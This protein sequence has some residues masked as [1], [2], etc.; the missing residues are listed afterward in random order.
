MKNALCLFIFLLI[1]LGRNNA[2]SQGLSVFNI[3]ASSFPNIKAKFFA[4]DAD[5]KQITNLSP[6]DFT[7]TEN[8]QP[9]VVTNVSCPEIKEPIALS[10]VLVI[11][12][13]GSM[14]GLPLAMAKAAANVWI[15]MIPLGKSE[16]A[17]TS[18]NGSSFVNQDFTTNKAKLV[19]SLS[20]LT[21]SDGTNYDAAF[22]GSNS[23]GIDVAKNG[24]HKRIIVFI[25]DG[26]GL[27]TD[28][29]IS[30]ANSY[31]IGVY[32]VTLGYSAPQC[33]KDISQQT[34]GLCFENI[35]TVQEA[36]DCYRKILTFAQ[37][38][39]PC[40]I[41][42]K[43]DIACSA[44]LRSAEVSLT[45]L[46]FTTNT[47]Y[48]SPFNTI[49][50]IEFSPRSIRFSQQNIGIKHDT[51]VTVKAKNSDFNVTGITSSNPAF[52][53]SPTSFYLQKDQSIDLTVSITP[54]DSAYTS[55]KF[56]FDNDK[57]PTAYYASGGTIGKKPKIPTLKLIHPN[58]G[59]LFV[60]GSDTV[61]T[62]DG[63][64]PTDTV[65]LEY[66]I[67][68]GKHWTFITDTANNF[69]YIWK[70]IPPPS[71]NVCLVK[72]T[73]L[74]DTAK[75]YKPGTLINTLESKIDTKYRYPNPYLE[76]KWN[77][78]SKLCAV[79][80]PYNSVSICDALNGKIMYELIGH[81]DMITS[82]SWS[83]F[84]DFIAT[85]SNDK[86]VKIWNSSNGSNLMTLQIPS[87]ALYGVNWSPDGTSVVT[88]CSNGTAIIWDALSGGI[89]NTL[90]GHKS[91]VNSAL[92]SPNGQYIGTSST[93][94]TV[95]IWEAITGNE[96]YTFGDTTILGSIKSVAWSPFGN[97]IS[98]STTICGFAVWDAVTKE[99]INLLYG[100][101]V[102]S[103]DDTRAAVV[104]PMAKTVIYDIR[105]GKEIQI[106]D[107]GAASCWNPDGTKLAT[108]NQNNTA[109]VWNALTGEKICTLTGHKNYLFSINWS[110][111]GTRLATTSLDSTAKIWY[112]DNVPLEVQSDESDAVFSIVSPKAT[113]KDINMGKC[114]LNSSKDSLV[115]EFISNFDSYKFRVDSIY[116][117]GP[118]AD[119]FRL[120]SGYPK[121]EVNP[122]ESKAAEFS[123][124]PKRIG[125]HNATINIITQSETLKQNIQGEG[126][127]QALEVISKLL[128]FGLVDL[129]SEKT[130]QDTVLIKNISA[131]PIDIDNVVQLGPD[132]K[133]F[134]IINGGGQFTLQPNES[135]KLTIRF[136][137]VYIGRTS[138]QLGFEYNGVGSPAIVQLF[139]IGVGGLLLSIPIDSAY[140]G[141]ER[142]LR[143]VMSNIKPEN[144]AAI[145][146]NFEAIIRFQKTIIT[147]INKADRSIVND[148]IYLKIKGTIGTS[149][150][151]AQIPVIAGLGFVEETTID[152]VDF[153]FTDKLGTKIDFDIET[154]SGTF[155]LLGICGEGGTRLINPTGKV[156]ILQIIPN[157]A[158]D[159]IEINV[160]LI[161][162]VATSLSVFNS[163][164]IKLKD[165]NMAGK[166]GLQTIN[167][168]IREFDNGL[169]FIKLQTPTVVE[170]QKL[171]II[172]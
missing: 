27:N 105:T 3:D 60:V 16:C 26:G 127:E 131:T 106:L 104:R 107:G 30:E 68:N 120:V 85:S 156:E 47:N 150:E 140:A 145:A 128:D 81:K 23:G 122:S 169:Y 53:I 146:S 103:P 162:D 8:G 92:W 94:R 153:K 136:K 95:K 2:N 5:G 62:W 126:V 152:I 18:F 86:T 125:I 124:I 109:I 113:S 143:L 123:F 35:M 13:S 1:L 112:V 36:E 142:S 165:F 24:K 66:S 99:L 9:R 111:D 132:K 67:D 117:T 88:P 167:L 84:G 90:T 87:A 14:D 64:L 110:P 158:S 159:D 161:E 39:D 170:N 129:G 78:D 74:A 71:S 93:D 135:R 25:S 54:V 114:A 83:P 118:D 121:Y 100:S 77:P 50:R 101:G 151:L 12:I 7:V 75:T 46:N 52:S 79:S 41:E 51:T 72:A 61:I 29:I 89:L 58:G 164:G 32:C 65:R 33:L 157:P 163:N 139:G 119:A 154:Q 15:D 168:D 6:S 130:I 144:I 172:K 91:S 116:F 21:A 37:G 96:I 44:G 48:Q 134:E 70:N 115:K 76:A 40:K 38:G 147:P 171:M 55:T 148:S 166:T 160:N 28:Q 59:E 4:F 98:T 102:W 19:S 49:A 56:T 34:G 141:E 149:L 63:I 97:Y 73:Q 45:S 82:I 20:Y 137:P 42:W 108:V 43:S 69:K 155:K 80:T 57:C 11:D 10:S 17:I 22:I 31:N 138:G 133:Q